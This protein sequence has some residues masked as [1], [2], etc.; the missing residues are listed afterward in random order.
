MLEYL[1]PRNHK[2]CTPVV[3]VL[4]KIHKAP[5]VNS[6]FAGRPIISG[7]GSPTEKNSEFVDYFLLPIVLQQSTYVKDISHILKILKA[8]PLPRETLLATLDVVFMYTNTPREEAL[9]ASQED[10][11]KAPK[12]LYGLNLYPLLP[13]A[14]F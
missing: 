13:F 1:S 2:I 10:F 9:N 6:K 7:N 11:E 5:P 14:L 8:T 4:P 3:H 12:N